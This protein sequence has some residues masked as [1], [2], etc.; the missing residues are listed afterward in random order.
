[1]PTVVARFEDGR[2][3]MTLIALIRHAATDWN[4]GGRVQSTT[5]VPLSEGGR[6]TVQS[7]HVPELL[8]G[9]D[10]VSSPLSRAVET[11]SILSGHP[12]SNVDARL[13]EMDWGAWEG[14]TISELRAEIGHPGE[15]WRAGGLDFKG[16]DGESQRDVQTRLLS[17]FSEV[18]DTMQ[19]TVIVCHRGIVR[20]TYSLA[21]NWDQTTA[22]P[23]TL[24]DDCTHLFRLSSD[25][26]PSIEELNVPLTTP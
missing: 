3:G 26:H 12:P 1:M 19:P 17:F 18:A 9:F 7:W 10:W 21:A 8:N 4:E 23:D 11:A 5:D 20:A 15:A 22:W 16:P 2:C 13:V 14:M 24:A 6:S 25:G